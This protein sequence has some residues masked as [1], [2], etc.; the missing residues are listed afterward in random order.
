MSAPAEFR[1]CSRCARF[2][3]GASEEPPRHAC[4]H[5]EVCAVGCAECVEAR[6]AERVK[7]ASR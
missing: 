1:Q 2:V 7:R 5:R 6:R 4:E 3:P